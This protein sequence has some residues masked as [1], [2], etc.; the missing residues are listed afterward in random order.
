MATIGHR[1]WSHFWGN[2]WPT[3]SQPRVVHV[4]EGYARQEA[5]TKVGHI[6]GANFGPHAVSYV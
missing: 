6:F 3:C 5:A 1:S 2:F 4:G